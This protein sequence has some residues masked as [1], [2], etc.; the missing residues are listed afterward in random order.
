MIFGT[1]KYP[2]NQ[3][4]LEPI[5]FREKKS[6]KSNTANRNQKSLL[7]IRNGGEPN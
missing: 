6:V 5:N 4:S 1:M 7:T 2:Q 3:E